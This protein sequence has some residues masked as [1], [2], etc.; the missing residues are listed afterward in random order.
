M[1]GN[2]MTPQQVTA[3]N[4]QG[5]NMAKAHMEKIGAYG[6]PRMAVPAV[7]K[8]ALGKTLKTGGTV[9]ASKRA[10]GIAQRG[11]TKGRMC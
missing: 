3:I 11:K 1:G 10:D 8:P 7:A 2:L 5:A 4:N 6:R 9:S